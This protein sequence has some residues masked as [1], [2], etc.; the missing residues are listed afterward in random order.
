MTDQITQDP[1]VALWVQWIDA[2]AARPPADMGGKESD[3]FMEEICD[4]MQVSLLFNRSTLILV[5]AVPL[6]RI[7]C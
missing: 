5:S 4:R 3:R 6:W 1:L 7:Q 2:R